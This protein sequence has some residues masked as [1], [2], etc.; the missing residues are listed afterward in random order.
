LGQKERWQWARV[1]PGQRERG[2]VVS[3][4]KPGKKRREKRERKREG[5]LSPLLSLSHF[6]RERKKRGRGEKER[7]PFHSACAKICRKVHVHMC[8]RK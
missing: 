8:W 2:V 7:G 1:G 5:E 4:S 3:T 6:Q